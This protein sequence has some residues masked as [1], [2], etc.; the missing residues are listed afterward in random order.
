[1][2]PAG[3][4]GATGKS[5]I[6]GSDSRMS[7]TAVAAG[8]EAVA[9]GACCA[10]LV[11]RAVTRGVTA[12][13]ATPLAGA[14]LPLT[15]KTTSTECTGTTPPSAPRVSST[16]PARGEVMVTVAL[17]VITSTMGWSSATASPGAISHLT[18]SPS[19]TPSPMSGSLNS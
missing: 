3:R 5:P 11:T 14:S 6:P 8:P 7:P 18:I 1:M 10:T 13:E 15:S 19:L 4:G 9:P 16:L 2:S 17:S 12:D